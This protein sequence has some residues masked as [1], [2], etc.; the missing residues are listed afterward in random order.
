MRGEARRERRQAEID[1]ASAESERE[2]AA[3]L[4]D[5]GQA[6]ERARAA[7]EALAAREDEIVGVHEL[8]AAR[9]P[10]QRGEYRRTAEQARMRARRVR[11][12]LRKFP[13]DIRACQGQVP[14]NAELG[15]VA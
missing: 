13:V 14:F 9:H 10:E 11:E 12:D 1:R 15:P 4:P 2:Q 7:M 3:V 5:P 6:I 8:L